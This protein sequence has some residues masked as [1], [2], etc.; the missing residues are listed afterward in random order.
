MLE[1]VQ[2]GFFFDLEN[3]GCRDYRKTADNDI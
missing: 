1:N 3:P 2:H